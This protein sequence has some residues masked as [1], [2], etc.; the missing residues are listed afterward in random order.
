[1]ANY[2]KVSKYPDCDFCKEEGIK[3]PAKYDGATTRGP[4]AYMCQDHY[5]Q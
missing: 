2:V 5:N 4:W 3:T 1:M